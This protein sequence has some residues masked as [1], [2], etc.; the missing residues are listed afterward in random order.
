MKKL[1]KICYSLPTRILIK[2]SWEI[3][4]QRFILIA[5]SAQSR[6]LSPRRCQDSGAATRS[7]IASHRL[8]KSRDL[9]STD[10]MEQSLSWEDATHLV[11]HDTPRFYGTYFKKYSVKFVNCI[12]LARGGIKFWDLVNT[13]SNETGSVKHINI[14]LITKLIWYTCPLNYIWEQKPCRHATST[15]ALYAAWNTATNDRHFQLC[16]GISFVGNHKIEPHSILG[17]R[18]LD[19]QRI[20]LIE[21]RAS[22]KPDWVAL[23]FCRIFTRQEKKLR[24]NKRFACLP[25]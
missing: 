1:Q 6:C 17:Q 24:W 5:S 10:L 16:T 22:Y 13:P 12:Q 21:I 3:C 20:F 2:A 8:L 23:S 19:Q 11:A 7:Q 15:P 9:P 25:E 4:S 18:D 14:K